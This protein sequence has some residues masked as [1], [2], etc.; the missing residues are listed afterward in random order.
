ML[1]ITVPTSGL[2]NWQY[3]YAKESCWP[4]NRYSFQVSK[5]IKVKISSQITVAALY[6]SWTPFARTNVGIVCSNRTRSMGVSS[7]NYPYPICGF[8][9][10]AAL[11][12]ADNPTK[13]LITDK[14]PRPD[15][16][17]VITNNNNSVAL[18]RKRTIPTERPPLVG[19][20]STNFC[21]QRGVA[22]RIPYGRNLSYID[23]AVEPLIII[24]IIIIIIIK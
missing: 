10:V 17:V 24:I 19:E 15:K 5:Y 18:V 1:V 20:V 3:R 11:W 12:Q 23:R 21:G 7:C 4:C 22:Q 9:C 2:L 13:E 8:L 16:R 6:K 14:A